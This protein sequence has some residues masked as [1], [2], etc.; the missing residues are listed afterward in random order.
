[1]SKAPVEEKTNKKDA[2]RQ[3]DNYYDHYLPPTKWG[4]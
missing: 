3:T 2:D 4:K 1:M